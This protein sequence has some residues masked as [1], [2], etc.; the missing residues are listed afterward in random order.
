MTGNDLFIKTIAY[1]TKS[2][3]KYSDLIWAFTGGVNFYLHGINVPLNDIDIQTDK[4]SAYKIEK[5]FNIYL[6]KP[7]CFLE[8]EKIKSHFGQLCIN[9]LR[10]EIMGDIQKKLPSGEWELLKDL[11]V[12]IEK[13]FFNEISFPVLNLEY[14]A[15]AYELLGRNKKANLIKN[16]FKKC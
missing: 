3:N 1:I 15:E 8:S 14:E 5:I 9:G 10:V 13:I 16:H 7:V 11:K 2:L 12:L 4:D 6:T